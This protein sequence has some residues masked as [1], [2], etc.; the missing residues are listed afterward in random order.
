MST[1]RAYYAFAD[2][3]SKEINRPDIG[4]KL[5]VKLILNTDE[6]GAKPHEDRGPADGEGERAERVELTD[7][8]HN[9]DPHTWFAEVVEPTEVTPPD[10]STLYLEGRRDPAFSGPREQRPFVKTPLPTA[11]GRAAN[12][13]KALSKFIKASPS[14]YIKLI[15]QYDTQ[16]YKDQVRCTD[17][18]FRSKQNPQAERIAEAILCHDTDNPHLERVNLLGLSGKSNLKPPM[19]FNEAQK[20]AYDSFGST[21]ELTLIHGPI[22]TGKTT[23]C[24]YLAK[25]VMSNPSGKS[26]ILYTVESNKAVDDV[27]LRLDK[28]CKGHGLEK[29]IL[30]G[31]T[32]KGEKN[33]MYKLFADPTRDEERYQID[34]AFVA[35]LS[36]IAY[37]AKLSRNHKGKRAQSDP[38]HV[39]A[40]MSIAEAM[41]DEIQSDPELNPL[42]IKLEE[43]AQAGYHYATP[44]LRTLINLELDGLM[45]RV[46]SC[47]DAIVC[48]LAA[49]A[50]VNLAQNLAPSHRLS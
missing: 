48:T 9:T 10:H 20:M 33:S 17:Q 5:K 39:L 26:Q 34:N 28:L 37:L 4:T 32:L 16:G 46:I 7:E 45:T 50:K 35:Q 6:N 36:T 41:H 22:G 11:N 19:Q 2:F 14:T 47:A 40:D 49:A 23:V 44:N 12:S 30:R 38:R 42:R 27:A 43:Y 21:S 29:K 18:F 13:I 15:M 25:D 3:T 1:A 24:L 8:D 31:H